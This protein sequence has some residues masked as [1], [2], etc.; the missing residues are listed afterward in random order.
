MTLLAC[1]HF[2]ATFSYA[3]NMMKGQ[4]PYEGL[5]LEESSDAVP[6][7]SLSDVALITPSIASLS[8]QSKLSPTVHGTGDMVLPEELVNSILSF[9]P[10]REWA[11]SWRC[12]SKH[13]S[14]FNF[15][16]DNARHVTIVPSEEC[17]TLRDGIS[18]AHSVT[19]ELVILPGVYRQ[20]LRVTKNIEIYG[21]GPLGSVIIE[22]KGW[23]DAL[24]RA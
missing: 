7:K 16:T 8:L 3:A 18:H 15:Y 22:A 11:R 1:L 24:V 19:R 20:A 21:A 5:I 9:L 10:W 12:V 2:I 6:S 14:P 23:E 17:P 13:F 4:C